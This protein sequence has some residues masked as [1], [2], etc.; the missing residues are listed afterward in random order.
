MF[1]PGVIALLVIALLVSVAFL[2]GISLLA[3]ILDRT[4]KLR[5]DRQDQGSPA[6]GRKPP[7]PG[8][9]QGHRDGD[10]GALA[11]GADDLQLPAK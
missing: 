7:E 8:C 1:L 5:E 6:D 3:W 2:G 9:L 10:G 11:G 4:R